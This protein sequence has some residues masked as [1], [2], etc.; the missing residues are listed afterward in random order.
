MGT[1]RFAEDQILFAKVDERRRTQ[2]QENRLDPQA[3]FVLPLDQIHK[4]LPLYAAADWQGEVVELSNGERYERHIQFEAEVA[5]QSGRQVV[6][7]VWAGRLNTALDIVTQDGVIIA[8]ICPNRYGMEVLVKP[9]YEKLTP[10]ALYDNPLL[11]Q[12][13]YGVNDLGA[14]RVPMRDGVRLA[15]DVYLPEGLAPGSRLPTIL[16]R[17]CYDRAGREAIFKRWAH[18]GYAVVSQDVRGRADSE[19]D[20]VP[21]YYEREDSSDTIDWIIA[22]DWSDGQVGMWGAS[23]LGYVAVAAATSGHPNLKAVVD[24]VNVGSPFVDTVR[25]GGTVCSWP[26]LCWT[27]AQSKGTR[28]DFDVFA[29]ITV[30]PEA[31]V[32][33]RPIKEIPQQVIGQASK[34]WDL[35]SEHPEYDDFWRNCTFTERGDQVK[36]PMFVISGWYDG[37][38]AG[39]SETWRMLT[40][41]DIPGRRIRLGPWEHG[42]NR[43]RDYGGVAFGNDAVVY[44]YDIAILR[45]FD[46]YLRGVDNGFEH[47]PRADYYVVGENT[48][49]TSADWPPVEA[50]T[51]CFYL[52][53]GGHANS[54]LGDG[55]L[56]TEPSPESAVDTYVYNPEEPFVVPGEREPENMRKYELR[57][58]ILVYTGEPLTAPLTVAGELSADIYAASTGLDTD[59]VATLCDVDESGN[60]RRLSSYIIRARYRH[61]LDQPELLIPGQ[62]EK[63]TI[64]MP[65]IA[66]NFAAGHRVRFTLTSSDKMVAFPNPNTGGNP[67]EEEP[68]LIVTQTLYHDTRCPSHIKL[69]IVE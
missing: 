60:S 43:A 68:P 13:L 35:W 9:G 59:W 45:F 63:Y 39:V 33:A 14:Y 18:K 21:F 62:V 55:S 24:E 46:R 56:L 29:G 8:F 41:H 42:P 37:D 69:P 36:T 54:S 10:L 25:R 12:P 65:K 20:L 2:M 4:Q 31:A 51:V 40:E 38:S 17:T 16:V 23:Y 5:S 32:D 61:G 19:G 7:Q 22:Q 6:A 48:W 34:P 58:D 1:L 66:Y 3:G 30:D 11:S 49:R 64:F 27:L 26:L 67:Y 44:D 28:T 52:G 50:K 57:H 47:E 53:S 15:T